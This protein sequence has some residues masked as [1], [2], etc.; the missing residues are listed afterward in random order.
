V[1]MAQSIIGML[2]KPED[3]NVTPKTYI[4]EPGMVACTC[5]ANSVDGNMR[6][7]LGPGAQS[8]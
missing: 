8:V 5:N 4:E 2:C 7:S 1:I 6:R 3:P